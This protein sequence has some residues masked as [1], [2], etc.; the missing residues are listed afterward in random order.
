MKAGQDFII[1]ERL[2][3]YISQFCNDQYQL[4]D[5][6]PTSQLEKLVKNR[7]ISRSW[8]KTNRKKNYA[9]LTI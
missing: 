7:R 8:Q 1:L 9:N 5:I 6:I 2:Q 4:S 3:L